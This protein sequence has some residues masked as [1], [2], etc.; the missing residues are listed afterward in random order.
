MPRLRVLAGPSPDNLTP[1]S[2]NS[3]MA[4]SIVSDTFEGEVVVHIKGFPDA[5]GNVLY[6]DYFSRKDRVGTTW[7]IQVQGRFLQY[8]SAD[9]ILFGNTFD[10]PLKLP[11]GAGAAL[12][13]MHFID[14]TLSHDLTSH[15]KPWALSPLIATMPH[16][17]HTS[18]LAGP[19]PRF[20]TRESIG[21][22]VSHLIPTKATT[23]PNG[24]RSRTP[25]PP[26]PSPPITAAKRRAYFSR[27]KTRKAVTF[28]PH[29][30]VTTDFCYGF[31]AFPDL[32]LSL[33]G[34]LSFDLT[35]YWD[36]QPVRFVC[37]QRKENDEGG[38]GRPF[39]CVAIELVEEDGESEGSEGVIG[40]KMDGVDSE[41]DVE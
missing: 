38:A 1:I 4:H 9:D 18:A 21:D 36:G 23:P 27:E 8:H 26:L 35:K 22:D 28:G 10:R 17:T 25:S 34:G 11:W 7:S 20:P 19:P 32:S 13:F 15:T 24:S 39:W 29:D 14:P 30:I 41:E 40:E 31:I 5:D 6:S 2:A 37:C 33:P 3:N 12:K 16:F